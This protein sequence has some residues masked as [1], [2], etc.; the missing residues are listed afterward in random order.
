[1]LAALYYCHAV[2]EDVMDA[3][4]VLDRRLICRLVGYG[5]R[6]EEDQVCHASRLQMPS[7]QQAELAAWIPG[8]LPDGGWQIEQTFFPHEVA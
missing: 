8:H 4:G 6:V 2:D 3:D 1:V 5:C 7:V